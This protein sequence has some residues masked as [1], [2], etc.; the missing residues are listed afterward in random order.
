[1]SYTL[2]ISNSVPNSA[3]CGV[4]IAKAIV[5]SNKEYP[6]TFNKS[7]QSKTTCNTD[8]LSRSTLQNKSVS[9]HKPASLQQKKQSKWIQNNHY[10]NSEK[11]EIDVIPSKLDQVAMH[12]KD[13]AKEKKIQDKCLYAKEIRNLN[14]AQRKKDLFIERRDARKNKK[15][16][17]IDQD[18]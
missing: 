11:K 17:L 8:K 5:E 16:F 1:M 12:L 9:T 3:L 15:S 13:E 10:K 7:V 4:I 14:Y 6:I 2:G 18:A